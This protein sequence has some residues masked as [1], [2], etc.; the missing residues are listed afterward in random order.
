MKQTIRNVKKTMEQSFTKKKQKIIK[1]MKHRKN[2][3][4][5]ICNELSGYSLPNN[6]NKAA[7]Q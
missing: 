1:T 4:K 5:L 2:S 6:K 3:K 7:K